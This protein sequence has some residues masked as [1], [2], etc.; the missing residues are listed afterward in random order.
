MGVRYLNHFLHDQCPRGMKYISFE[1]LRG[2]TIV[3]DVSI[4]LYKFKAFDEFLKLI[5]QM[6]MDFIRYGIHGI[7]FSC[8]INKNNCYKDSDNGK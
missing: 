8:L 7:F 4:Y 3:V 1:E 5:K 2:K 6:L